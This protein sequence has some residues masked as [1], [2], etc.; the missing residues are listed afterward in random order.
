M[1]LKAGVSKFEITP[2]QPAWLAGYGARNKP[3][4]GVHDPLFLT[5]LVLD[6]G[7]NRIAMVSTDLCF[8]PLSVKEKIAPQIEAKLSILP[9]HLIIAATHTHSGPVTS[10]RNVDNEWLNSFGDKMTAAINE[11]VENMTLAKISVGTGTSNVGINRRERKPDGTITLGHNEDGFLDRQVGVIR[12]DSKSG[13]AI[14]TLISYGCHGTTL[15]GKNYLISADYMGAAVRQ[16]Q[17]AVGGIVT[18]FNGAPGNVDPAHRV[19]VNFDHVEELGVKLATE[20]Q[21]VLKEKMVEIESDPIYV[22]P[23]EIGLPL[24]APKGDGNPISVISTSIVRIGD[25][26]FIMFPGEMFAQTGMTLKARSSAKH[27]FPIS[28]FCGKSAGYLP[29]RPVYQLGGYEV[30]TSRHSPDAEE[31]YVNV[32]SKLISI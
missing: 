29:I 26:Q 8:A 18:F 10:G 32:V 25:L 1:E 16:V 2:E 28:Y 17:D 30:N 19:G 12:I 31:I 23:V 11:A 22:I 7:I 27:P 5:A 3:S 6:N 24:K 9:E 14:A 15:G 13:K 20:V 4:E 21:R